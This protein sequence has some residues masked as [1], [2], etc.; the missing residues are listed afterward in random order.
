MKVTYILIDDANPLHRELSICRSGTINRIRLVDGQYRVY[1]SL[2]MECHDYAAFFHYGLPEELNN[3]PFISE[4][5]SGL[6][7]WDEAYLH[8]AS[9]PGLAKLIAR[10]MKEIDPEK[11]ETILLGWQDEPVGAAYLREIDPKRFLK[12]L[13]RLEYFIKTALHEEADLEFIL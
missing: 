7:S 5:G 6:D 3:L 10:K 12:F 8:Q 9:L 13:D 4:S 11:Q 2:E 1:A